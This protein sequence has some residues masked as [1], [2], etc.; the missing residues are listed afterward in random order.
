M[1]DSEKADPRP[2]GAE[3]GARRD[4]LTST[5]TVGRD[6]GERWV[7]QRFPVVC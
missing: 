3:F 1:R 6:L 2:A 5:F 4:R 7:A